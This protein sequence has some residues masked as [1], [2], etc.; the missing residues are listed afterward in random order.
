MHIGLIIILALIGTG[1]VSQELSVKHDQADMI[2]ESPSVAV[3]EP[4]PEVVVE[5]PPE[6]AVDHAAAAMREQ[7]GIEIS[8]VRLSAGGYIIDFR[9]KVFDPVKAK[10]LAARENK[11]YL[12]DQASGYKLLVPNTP[13]LGPLRQT[14]KKLKKGTIYF[15]LF[16][17]PGRLVKSGS[18]V[19]VVIG[20]FRVENIEVQ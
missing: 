7:W 14:T 8:S 20:E 15:A 10:A 9:Y 16:A 3:T 11:P 13:K 17:N 18:K 19:T 5:P 1:C 12:I 6:P 4:Q 2:V